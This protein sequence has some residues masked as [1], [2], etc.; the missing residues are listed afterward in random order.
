MS[1]YQTGFSPFPYSLDFG[2]CLNSE[3]ENPEPNMVYTY[4]GMSK[5]ESPKLG[6]RQNQ[7]TPVSHFGKKLDHV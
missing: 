5:S 6:K 3:L 2:R 4:S 1:G 7:D